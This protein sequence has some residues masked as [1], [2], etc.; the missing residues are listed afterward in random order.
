MHPLVAVGLV[1]LTALAWMGTI[2]TLLIAWAKDRRRPP[3]AIPRM[4]VNSSNK[5]AA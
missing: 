2:L 3:T 5:T 4:R 1:F